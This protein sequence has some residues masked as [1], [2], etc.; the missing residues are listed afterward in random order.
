[1]KRLKV[2][3]DIL[4][5]VCVL[6]HIIELQGQNSIKHIRK[7][8]DQYFN[9]GNYLLAQQKYESLLNTKGES[10]EV[11]KNLGITYYHL[12]KYD[13]ATLL[14]AALY[15]R[16]S[17]DV[18][19]PFYLG[20]IAQYKLNFDQAILLFK[21][22]LK[23][24]NSSDPRYRAVIDDLKRCTNGRSVVYIPTNS[25]V[26]NMGENVNS[27]L[28]EF[29][30]VWSR[31][32]KDK[33]YFTAEED[34]SAGADS[35]AHI[36][37][38]TIPYRFSMMGT[39]IE[40]GVWSPSYPLNEL[41]NTNADE[42]LYG[43]NGNGRSVYYGLKQSPGAIQLMVNTLPDTGGFVPS[44]KYNLPPINSDPFANDF[45]FFTDSLIVY[46][47]IRLGG[48]GGYD[49]YFT[50]CNN[51]KWS[52]PENLGAKI[53]SNYDERYPFLAKDGRTLFFAS[54][55]LKSIG[56]FDIF[57]SHYDDQTMTWSVPENAGM[58]VNSAFNDI[59]LTLSPD[60]ANAILSSDR[61]RGYGNMDLYT[62]VFKQTMNEQISQSKPLSFA[63][64]PGYKRFN[65]E[66]ATD[67][68]D[69]IVISPKIESI[70][71]GTDETNLI[72][73]NKNALDK[74]IAL[75][76]K[77]P[78]IGLNFTIYGLPSNSIPAATEMFFELKSMD[79]VITYLSDKGISADRVNLQSVGSQYPIAK[80]ILEGKPVISGQNLNR[81]IDVSLSNVDSLPLQATYSL[82]AVNSMLKLNNYYDYRARLNGLSYRIQ[83]ISLSQ[84]YKGDNFGS[85]PDLMIESPGTSGIYKYLVG[86]FPTYRQALALAGI[87]KGKGFPDAY[88]VPYIDNN[89]IEKKDISD[90]LRQKYPDLNNYYFN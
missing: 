38:T 90:F 7:Q 20:K 35:L 75:G 77:F 19:A 24:S 32:H 17:K 69:K 60:G 67:T 39:E 55:S 70:F 33:I 83:V 54:N 4:I 59:Q 45:N 81:R 58:P 61:E 26:E 37:S 51:G 3:R 71:Y 52:E 40:Q 6:C 11:Q 8:G 25:Y 31:N 34:H 72:Q 79:K 80:I 68:N 28:I 82:P 49:L 30:P 76:K 23:I 50:H 57:Y 88:V 84:M 42:Y 74:L 36:N 9:S 16:D 21:Y 1:V 10:P 65:Q 29:G 85:E 5:L 66:F 87:L 43:F 2:I 63:E 41:L 53:N 56:G 64:V 89:R 12:G 86:L 18:D 47:S 73:N 14:L 48:L 62:V 27:P 44:V 15:Q 46:S 22:F 13:K 78:T